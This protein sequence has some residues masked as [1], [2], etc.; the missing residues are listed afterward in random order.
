MRKTSKLKLYKIRKVKL[1]TGVRLLRW[2]QQLKD[3][4][5]KISKLQAVKSSGKNHRRRE[6]SSRKELLM[7]S[8]RACIHIILLCILGNK[9]LPLLWSIRSS[10]RIF[11]CLNTVIPTGSTFLFFLYF[12]CKSRTWYCTRHLCI[13]MNV[14]DGHPK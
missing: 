3:S 4:K 12:F 6:L 11:P 2:G 7:L 9:S 13:P 8:F 1:Q 10:Q 14:K 5:G